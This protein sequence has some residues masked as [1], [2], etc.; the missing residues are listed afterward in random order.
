MKK[1]ARPLHIRN[2]QTP[3]LTWA[4]SVGIMHVAGTGQ[5]PAVERQDAFVRSL[6]IAVII[7][8]PLLIR[9]SLSYRQGGLRSS[10]L[11][12]DN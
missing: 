2:P 6:A 1:A 5:P 4:E 8:S 3:K 9:I 7:K 11:R 12:D 10:L